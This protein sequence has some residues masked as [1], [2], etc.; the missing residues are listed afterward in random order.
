MWQT[1]RKQ[2]RPN[3]NVPFFNM[4]TT[5]V[6]DEFKLYWR[7]TFISTDKLVYM[8]SDLSEDQLENTITMI[9]NSRESVDEMLA[10]PKVQ[11]ELIT[12]KQ[13]YLQENGITE[14]L[15]SNQEV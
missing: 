15:I 7:D 8:H 10:D 6:S 4:R 1:V 12:V 5:L 9:W 11:A 3:T 2:I 13:A 14:V